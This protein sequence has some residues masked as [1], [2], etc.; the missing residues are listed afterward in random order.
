MKIIVIGAQGTIGKNVVT[1]LEKENDTEI[2][3]VGLDAGDFRVDMHSTAS[4]ENLFKQI[5]AFDALVV[6]AGGAHFGPLSAM[7]DE[8]FREGI[9]SKLMGQVNLVLIGQHYINRKGSFTLV[10]GTLAEDP[11][12]FAANVSAVNAAINGFVTGASIE[13]ENGLRINAVSPSVVE[14]SPALHPFF[15]GH[16]PVKAERV[17]QAYIKSIYGALSGQVFKVYP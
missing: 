4:I 1:A 8:H 16:T 5:G 3:K 13:L 9:N 14:E 12:P 15:K 7:T 2:I 6:A 11:I 10:S 17:A